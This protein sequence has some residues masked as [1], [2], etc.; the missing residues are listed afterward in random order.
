[1]PQPEPRPAAPAARANTRRVRR[2]APKGSTRLHACRNALGLGPNIAAALL[3]VS[4]AGVRLLLREGLTV[5]HEFEVRL[6]GAAHSVKRIARVIWCVATAD[7]L[8]CV[9]ASFGQ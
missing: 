6:E 2:H 4:E 5:G 9:G 8:F 7:G 1:M 3:D